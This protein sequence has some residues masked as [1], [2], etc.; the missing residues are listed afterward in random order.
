MRQ[1]GPP[2]VSNRLTSLKMVQSNQVTSE[3]LGLRLR[4]DDSP[5]SL[6]RA[7]SLSH[8]HTHN[9]SI[10]HWFTKSRVMLRESF[11]IKI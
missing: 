3:P 5:L 8:T 11:N 10:L 2:N 6:A 1:D 7:L 4:S 9:I